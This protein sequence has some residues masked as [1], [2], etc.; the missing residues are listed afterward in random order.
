MTRTSVPGNSGFI[1]LDALLGLVLAGIAALAVW[2][3][4]GPAR[5]AAE[6]AAYILEERN[7]AAR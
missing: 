6:R 4:T 7:H 3:M 2:G 1:L 5:A